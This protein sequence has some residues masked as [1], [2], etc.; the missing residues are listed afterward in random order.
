MR[1]RWSASAS[2]VASTR[3]LVGEQRRRAPSRARKARRNSSL[4]EEAVQI[5]AGDAAVGADRAVRPAAKPQHRPRQRRPG[6]AA[7]MHLVAV[8][9]R[10]AGDVDAARRGRAA[11]RRR[12]RCR[13]R[14]GRAPALSRRGLRCRAGS[15]MRRGR[16]SDSRRKCPSTAPPRRRCARMSMSQ[17]SRRSAARSASVAFDPGRITS[18]ASR[19]SGRPGAHQDELD[20]R[21]RRAAGRDRRNWRSAAAAARRS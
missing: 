21:A 19:G 3:C 16:A 10:A 12:A 18:A 20:I 15:A 1:S 2:S 14:A 7:E 13:C 9:R 11:F 4:G 6:G 8:D 5:A 17:P